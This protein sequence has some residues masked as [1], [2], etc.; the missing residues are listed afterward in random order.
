ML[1][2]AFLP[3]IDQELNAKVRP[4]HLEYLNDLYKQDKVFMAGPFT[5]KE[6]G[7]VIYKASSLEEARKLAEADPVVAEGA[8]TLELREWNPLELPLT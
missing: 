7:L 8:R 5:D 3:I 2:V 6:G 1:Y 4:A